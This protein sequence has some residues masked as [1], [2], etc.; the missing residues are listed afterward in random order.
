MEVGED[1][2]GYCKRKQ[3]DKFLDA[4]DTLQPLID[5]KSGTYN[6]FLQAENELTKREFRKTPEDSE[7]CC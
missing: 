7:V 3:P 2:V 6:R 4:V 1:A 5:A